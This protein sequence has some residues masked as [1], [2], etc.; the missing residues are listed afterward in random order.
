[1]GAYASGDAAWR[2]PITGI[3]GG[4]ACAA[5]GQ[6]AILPP[7]NVMN[8]RRLTGYPQAG[9]LPYHIAG[10]VVRHSKISHPMTDTGHFRLSAPVLPPGPLPLLPESGL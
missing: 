8:S 6:A 4:C 2:N 3:A 7:I 5:R 1:M 9:S 10:R